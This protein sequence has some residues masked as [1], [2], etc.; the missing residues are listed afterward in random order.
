[1]YEPITNFYPLVVQSQTRRI[2]WGGTITADGMDY[3]FTAENI[4]GGSGRI[5]NEIAGSVMELGTVYSSELDIGLYIDDIGVPRDKIYGA[6]IVIECTMTA[7]NTTGT[8]P[9]GVF[10]VVEAKQ[11]GAVC[12][13]VA[14]DGMSAFDVEYPIE[15]GAAT[16]YEWAVQF[17]VDCGVSLS[18]TKAQFESM[19]NGTVNLMLTWSDSIDTY[20]TAIGMLAAAIGCS[21]HMNRNGLLEFYPLKNIASVAT[22]RANDRFSS[23]IAQTSWQPN[24][25]YVTNKESG[26][27]TKVGT[28]SLIISLG[29]NGYLQQSGIIRDLEWQITSS[30]SVSAMLSSIYTVIHGVSVVPTDADIPL[31]PCLDLFD[32][33]TL[34]GGQANNTKVLLT[35]L[36]HTIG[37]ATQI[38]CAGSNTSEEP[39]D[40]SRGSEGDRKDW[41]WVSGATNDSARV[42]QTSEQTWQAQLSTTWGAM[43]SSTWG[44]L[45]NGGDWV[46]LEQFTRSFTTEFTL[47]VIGLTTEYQCDKDTDVKFKIAIEKQTYDP[48]LGWQT[49]AVTQWTCTEHAL[50]GKHTISTVTPFGILDRDP[51]TIYLITAYISGMDVVDSLKILTKAEIEALIGGESS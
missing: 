39:K 14:Y 28:G 23:G 32:I 11:S 12:S 15:S 50:K 37:G 29:E 41:M 1:M 24:T 36:I 34:T 33:V 7:N 51:G 48:D 35:S 27:L 6:K 46:M 2:T 5:V 20:R 25:L 44:G 45:L 21:A 3:T 9:M 19:P 10:Y 4:V 13:I 49:A 26:K 31:N 40:S 16:P 17:C 43:L 22:V 8:V 42:V 30:K 38:K 47:G 18:T